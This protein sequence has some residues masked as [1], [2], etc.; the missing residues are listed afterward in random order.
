MRRILLVGLL[1]VLLISIAACADPGYYVFVG[2]SAGARLIGGGTG[3]A[4]VKDAKQEGTETDDRFNLAVPVEDSGKG[5]PIAGT[6]RASCYLDF[7]G[8]IHQ[9]TCRIIEVK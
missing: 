9:D 1:F 3:I 7:F 2:N 4:F 5:I 6:V 8:F